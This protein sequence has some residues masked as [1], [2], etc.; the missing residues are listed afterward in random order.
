MRTRL[1]WGKLAVGL[2][3][4]AATVALLA[5]AADLVVMVVVGAILAYLLS[6]LVNRLEGR[7]LSR[8]VAASIVFFGLFALFVAVVYFT[9]PLV[10]AQVAK[11][12]V[13]WGEGRLYRVLDDLERQVA[14]WI[15]LL[16]PGSLGL[17]AAAARTLEEQSAH[18]LDFLSGTLSFLGD[19]I[20]IP[21]VLFFLLRDGPVLQRQALALVPNRYFEF[22]MNMRYQVDAHLGGYLRGQALIAL[23]VGALTALG[24]AVVGVDYYL[25]LGLLAGVANLV[26]YIG[27]LVSAA[28]TLAVSVLSTGGFAEVPG[29][30]VVF[31]IVQ[32]V[33]NVVLQ[34]WITSR[35][36]SLHPVTILLAILIGGRVY[37]VVGM[38]LAV[39][40]AAILKVVLYETIFNLRRY[41]L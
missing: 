26:P 6:P 4:L 17:S 13:R 11:L 23:L 12:Q 10:A 16:E 38:A 21:F 37:G 28:V 5:V 24:L 18:W 34:P 7:G 2:A 8:T 31:A 19:A 36:V 22:A 3:V 15:P 40:V 25:L 29:I 27:L 39:P 32:T 20:V 1:P 30:V 33:E 9:L 35:N 41:R 14:A